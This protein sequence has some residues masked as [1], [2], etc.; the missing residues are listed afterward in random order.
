M[1]VNTIFD[2]ACFARHRQMYGVRMN[3]Y[4]YSFEGW[5]WYAEDIPH[6]I[7]RYILAFANGVDIVSFDV[8]GGGLFREQSSKIQ[9]IGWKILETKDKRHLDTGSG[10]GYWEIY[11]VLQRRVLTTRGI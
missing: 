6:T 7:E 10:N 5:P 1:A 9:E 3:P 11:F 8:G 4:S 2:A